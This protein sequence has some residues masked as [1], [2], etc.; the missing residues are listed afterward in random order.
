VSAPT[1]SITGLT[2]AA[3]LLSSEK[4]PL[5]NPNEFHREFLEDEHLDELVAALIRHYPQFEP[6]GDL[7]IRVLWQKD[8]GK[9]DGRLKLGSLSKQNNMTRY[10]A[11]VDYVVVVNYKAAA[12]YE[13]TNWQM[14]ALLFHQLEHIEIAEDDDGEVKLKTRPHDIGLFNSEIMAYGAWYLDLA[15]TSN[16]FQ[17]Q[18]LWDDRAPAAIAPSSG[19]ITDIV[20]SFHTDMQRIAD[21]DGM[22][23]TLSAGG[24]S[25]TIGPT[26]RTVNGET[27]ERDD[28]G[29]YVNIETGEYLDAFV[30]PRPMATGR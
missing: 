2:P 3:L 13:L 21:R 16:A 11:K 27:F 4:F 28:L 15:N 10:L 7:T 23:T 20:Q 5:P 1:K 6:F 25:V 17:Q 12:V 14:E 29:R 19:P 9:E 24:K 22:T 8:A 18:P 26:K 30:V